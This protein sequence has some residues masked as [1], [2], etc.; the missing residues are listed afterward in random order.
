[1][2]LAMESRRGHP[3]LLTQETIKHL[4]KLSTL[5]GIITHASRFIHLVDGLHCLLVVTLLQWTPKAPTWLVEMVSRGGWMRIWPLLKCS[6]TS[7]YLNWGTPMAE[8]QVNIHGWH[9]IGGFSISS[10]PKS[11]LECSLIYTDHV[12]QSPTWHQT[13][14]PR[15]PQTSLN[16]WRN[17]Q[18]PY[19]FF[20]SE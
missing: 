3:L 4:V 1:M 9:W 6:T 17:Q 18:G 2:W 20:S 19:G 12:D 16:R 5:G 8:W 13:P 11:R 7:K 15:V 10:S 14:H